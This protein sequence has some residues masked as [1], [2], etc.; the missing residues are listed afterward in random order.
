MNR[1][2]RIKKNFITADIE[3]CIDEVST[4]DLKYLIAEHIPISVG[5]TW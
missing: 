4:N 3:C 5:Y 1:N 2:V